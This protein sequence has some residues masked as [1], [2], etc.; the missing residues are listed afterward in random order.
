MFER[1]GDGG[2]TDESCAVFVGVRN[3]STAT[4]RVSE[5]EAAAAG[6]TGRVKGGE[7]RVK[8]GGRTPTAEG[9]KD[10]E[11]GEREDEVA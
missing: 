7:G 11:G 6:N 3:E 9:S 4:G 5:P 10:C 2:L 8:E 1:T